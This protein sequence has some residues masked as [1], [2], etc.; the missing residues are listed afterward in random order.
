MLHWIGDDDVEEA[1]QYY[2]CALDWIEK[3]IELESENGIFYALRGEI[4]S[5]GLLDYQKAIEA[6][7]IAITKKP[8]DAWILSSAA[9]LYDVPDTVVTLEEAIKWMESCIEIAPSEGI[10]RARL[11]SLYKEAGRIP[12]MKTQ[13]SAALLLSKPI[14]GILLKYICELAS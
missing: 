2:L 3:A 11:A 14:D 6:Y 9:S 8:N 1:A 13:L 10:Y 7:R 12:E 5:L 4:Y